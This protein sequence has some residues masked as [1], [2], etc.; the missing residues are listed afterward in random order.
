MKVYGEIT[1]DVQEVEISLKGYHGTEIVSL[2]FV[3]DGSGYTLQG[4]THDDRRIEF[5]IKENMTTHKAEVCEREHCPLKEKMPVH[6]IGH[7]IEMA[8]AKH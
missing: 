8:D 7:C 6:Y 5:S 2:K 4:W 1:S 3:P